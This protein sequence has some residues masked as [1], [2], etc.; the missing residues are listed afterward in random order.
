[1]YKHIPFYIKANKK[2][3]HAIGLYYNNSYESVFDMG[4]E[5]SGYWPR[6]SYFCADGGDVDLFLINGPSMKKVIQRYTDLTGKTAFVPMQALGYLGSTMY[7]AEL[8]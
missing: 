1:M 7:Y 6:Y 8:E 3:K 2:S 5:K 4:C